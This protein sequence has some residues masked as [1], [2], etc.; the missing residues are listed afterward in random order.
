[1]KKLLKT[2]ITL[3]AIG[4]A[5]KVIKRKNNDNELIIT[6]D[7]VTSKKPFKL[8][9][10]KDRRAIKSEL[11]LKAGDRVHVG[12]NGIIAQRLEKGTPCSIA[13]CLQ[14]YTLVGFEYPRPY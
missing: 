11:S 7:Y 2:T 1:M 12:K 3:A 6:D 5:V 13:E 8:A 10:F 4:V 9:Q 14:G